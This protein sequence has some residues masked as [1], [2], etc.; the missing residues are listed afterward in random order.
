MEK[1]K[2]VDK[3]GDGINILNIE[4]A[5]FCE[6]K[7]VIALMG[8]SSGQVGLAYLDLNSPSLNLLHINDDKM[9]SNTMRFLGEDCVFEVILAES[10]AKN[11]RLCKIIQRGSKG[12][13][14]V[15]NNERKRN[16]SVS[17]VH[18]STFNE[19]AGLSK[20]CEL[21]GD[22]SFSAKRT[23]GCH[24]LCNAA[25]AALLNH[26]N[27]VYQ[28]NFSPGSVHVQQITP[29]NSMFIDAS[30]VKDLELLLNKKTNSRKG[31]LF[32]LINF[33]NTRVGQKMLKRK[34]LGPP[35]DLNIIREYHVG[36]KELLQERNLQSFEDLIDALSNLQDVDV[37]TNFFSSKPKTYSVSSL[38][39]E[40]TNTIR[41]KELISQILMLPSALEGMTSPIFTDASTRIRDHQSTFT[42]TI[43]N[44]NKRINL[45][46]EFKRGAQER[47]TEA[48]L[49]VKRNV[50]GLLDVSRTTY[51]QAFDKMRQI[52]ASYVARAPNLKISLTWTAQRG[53]HIKYNKQKSMDEENRHQQNHG[54]EFIRIK[55][56]KSTIKC[57]TEEILICAER[58]KVSKNE[59]LDRSLMVLND[60]RQ[61]LRGS[62]CIQALY[63]I[64]DT[65]A[66][67]D[68]V[69]AIA[70][71]SHLFPE[72]TFPNVGSVESQSSFVIKNFIH[73][74]CCFLEKSSP[75][76]EINTATAPNKALA[77]TISLYQ[78][79][80]KLALITG[81][82][83]SGK[84][85]LLKAV[86]VINVMSHLGFPVPAESV[87]MPVCKNLLTRIGTEDD[88]EGNASTFSVE[89]S[90]LAKIFSKLEESS[91]TTNSSL[92]LIDELGR[93][94]APQDGASIAW[95]SLE[96]FLTFP[97]FTL[98]VSHYSE[99]SLLAHQIN[100]HVKQYCFKFKEVEGVTDTGSRSLLSFEPTHQLIVKNESTPEIGDFPY[101]IQAAKFGGF[102]EP[103]VEKALNIRRE[104]KAKHHLDNKN[105]AIQ[106]YEMFFAEISQKDAIAMVYP[107]IRLVLQN[108][109]N[110]GER[111]IIQ[112]VQQLQEK[113]K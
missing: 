101:G 86:G 45:D 20:L 23:F 90:D 48:L 108:F 46:V 56:L 69:A 85:T 72:W 92:V 25:A 39:R 40:I 30:T 11:Q 42:E 100:L 17:L 58:M 68:Y 95:A 112:F 7:L 13:A 18:R 96:H 36:A 81:A 34:I 63:N 51:V 32:D 88:L 59:I 14:S 110:F 6:E 99:L 54:I 26:L 2:W 106:D 78:K 74:L 3:A 91:T 55:E 105:F 113:L 28:L 103:V 82:N 5:G 21:A 27:K 41:L 83:S 1:E 35:T 77:N 109:D 52:I 75:V 89:M 111:E 70:S 12:I 66:N 47:M 98:F 29:K 10:H 73:P 84:S 15:T 57:T 50:D 8:N 31:S 44:I 38:L 37:L 104:L 97:A 76:N 80:Q 102:P 67:I 4:E 49:A 62:G 19:D 60:L 79:H 93:G 53:Y 16:P 22:D 94:T 61:T 33:T 71:A 43:E 107:T 9:F 87:E 24:Y 65:I 64:T